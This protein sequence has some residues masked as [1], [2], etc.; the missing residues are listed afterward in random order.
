MYPYGQYGRPQMPPGFTGM[1][2]PSFGM[3]P[4]TG[5]PGTPG[6]PPPPGTGG[7]PPGTMQANMPTRPG[8]AGF[9][10]PA[11]LPN[12]NFNAP[13]IRLGT[14]VTRQ[15]PVPSAGGKG[16]GGMGG[17]G[18]MF[19]R[20]AV[21]D[22]VP[23]T[24]EE[25][26]KTVFVGGIPGSLGDEWMEKILRSA[27]NLKKWA[28]AT[29]ENGDPCKFGFAEYEDPESLGCAIEV[30]KDLEIPAVD[31]KGEAA[32][33]MVVIDDNSTTFLENCQEHSERQQ[34]DYASIQQSRIDAAR[35]AIAATISELNDPTKRASAKPDT[36]ASPNT[37]RS[38]SEA[39]AKNEPETSNTQ[40]QPEIVTIPLSADDELSDIPADMREMVAKEIAA[41]R[42]RSNRRDLERLKREE[43]IEK[44]ERERNAGP[45]INR[46]ASSPPPS[47]APTGPSGGANAIPIGPSRLRGDG[48]SSRVPTGPS[49]GVQVPRDYQKGVA[50]VNGNHPNGYLYS[51]EEEDSDASDE[52]LERRRKAKKAAD[53]E[54]NFLDHERRWLNRERSR[55]SALEREQL[56]DAEDEVREAA[57]KQAMAKRLEAWDDDVE[58]EKK[59]EEYYVD[60]SVWIRNRAA[61]RAREAELDDRDRAA[62]IRQTEIDGDK[63]RAAESMADSFLARQAEEMEKAAATVKEPQKFKL[64]LGAAASKK[65]EA[66]A[67][68]RKTAAE[69]EGLLEDE[70]EDD[71]IRRRVL[72]PITYDASSVMD[73][74][75]REKLVKQLAQ[76]IPSDRS[77]LF[78]WKVQW[79][80]VDEAI[81][82]EK[83]QPF[84]EKKIMEY[85]GVQEQEL[86]GFVLDHI[87]KRGTA[88]NLVKELEMALGE[89]GETMVKKVWRMV[90]FYSES[91]KRGLN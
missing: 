66:S 63:K 42:E 16:M 78:D 5:A 7:A 53:A 51:K 34:P 40:Q 46:L 89:D 27:A 55:T 28:R 77:G 87:R 70:E 43:E 59:I 58:A 6:L 91:E 25:Q 4:G 62:E 13:I 30:L 79:D 45:R 48:P 60:R 56:R 67:P 3:P 11:N 69:V 21:V 35:A 37:T 44:M 65:Q 50:F 17:G 9:V 10:P 41:F 57:E 22:L 61:F 49:A 12:I 31:D 32:K 64:A 18:Q 1:M 36:T 76:E 39:P 71:S 86:V 14:S 52:E 80:H 88:E 73:E 29:N 83:L 33:L 54:K 72:V 15:N 90:I 75:T 74:E 85:L 47:S 23:P 2:P 38:E 19:S 84:V 26:L 81:I 82:G 20:E 68:R 8:M 24:V